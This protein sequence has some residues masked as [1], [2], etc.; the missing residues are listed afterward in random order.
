MEDMKKA[1]EWLLSGAYTCVVCKDGKCVVSTQR[2]VAPLVKWL[3]S[4]DDFKGYYAADKVIGK[5][6]AF[7]YVLL[8]IKAVYAGVISK[9]ALRVLQE[10]DIATEYDKLVE[11]IINRQGDGI[12]PFEAAVL[13][14]DNAKAAYEI[15]QSK[16]KEMNILIS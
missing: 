9:T 7:L 6:T 16:M 1:K 4:G 2:G 14:V 8:G 12:C 15:I 13:D 5:A 11:N 3:K 10:H